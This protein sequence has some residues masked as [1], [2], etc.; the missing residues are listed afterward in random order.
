MSWR[1]GVKDKTKSVSE[2]LTLENG[3]NSNPWFQPPLTIY[4]FIYLRIF[5]YNYVNY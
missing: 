4:L 5:I 1:V 2:I 3:S